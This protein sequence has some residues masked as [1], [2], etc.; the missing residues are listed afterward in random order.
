[1]PWCRLLSQISSALLPSAFLLYQTMLKGRLPHIM[2]DH[3]TSEQAPQ[4]PLTVQLNSCR[5]E[6]AMEVYLSAAA[7]F[8][9]ETS[10]P[11]FSAAS[12]TNSSSDTVSETSLLWQDLLG[13]VLIGLGV[14]A[15]FSPTLTAVD[16]ALVQRSAGSHTFA[17]SMQQSLAEMARDPVRYL[18]S[19][20]FLWMWCCYAA[21]YATA[22]C[23]Q[24]LAQENTRRREASHIMRDASSNPDSSSSASSRTIS[25]DSAGFSLLMFLGTTAANS[26]AALAKDRAYSRMFG[27]GVVSVPRTSYGLWLCRD[28]TVVGSSFLLPPT[29][30]RYIDA[31]RSGDDSH[32]ASTTTP[33][34]AQSMAIAQFVTPLTAQLIAGPLHYMGLDY[35]NRSGNI[36]FANRLAHL[37]A[38]LASVIPA[39]MVRILPGYGMG[40]VWNQQGRQ[41]WKD[42]VRSKDSIFQQFSLA[43]PQTSS[44]PHPAAL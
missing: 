30:A 27:S 24:T 21:T 26:S 3:S 31:Y 35:A 6:P 1:M 44:N 11:D 15:A 40:G 10:T 18:K 23:F 2:S 9:V 13:D 39:R 17:Q 41:A 42:H 20:T 5:C 28:L 8:R 38:G 33:P 7:D 36:S 22:N 12:P 16:K 37:R 32:L 43:R 4:R 29:V 14:T 19:P 25:M 34:S